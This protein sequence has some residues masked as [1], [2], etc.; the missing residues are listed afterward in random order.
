MVSQHLYL[1]KTPIENV[2]DE[3]LDIRQQY[4]SQN[5][6][7]TDTL[8]GILKILTKA[9]DDESAVIKY[10]FD[11]GKRAYKNNRY[12][13]DTEKWFADKFGEK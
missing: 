10:A 13:E 4:F 1:M 7:A 9:L 2:I 12:Y 5:Q 11:H 6:I 8:D 3:L